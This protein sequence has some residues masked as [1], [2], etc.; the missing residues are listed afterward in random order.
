[1][2]IPRWLPLLLGVLTA[3]GPVSIDMYLPA[4]PAIEAALGGAPG[5]AQV[6]LATFFA[7][8]ALGQ[9]TQGSLSDRLGRRGPLI[10]GTTLYTLASI[11]CALAPSLFWLALFRL[12]AAFGGSASMVIPRA[13]VRDLTEGQAAARLMSRLMLVMGAA[14][15]LAPSLG[16]LVLA[17]GNWQAIFWIIALYGAISTLLVWRFLPDTLPTQY[18]V[19]LGPGAQAS[20]YLDILRERDFITHALC[21]GFCSFA[22]FAYISGSPSVF[23]DHF[24]LRP[25]LFAVVFGAC[26]GGL[27]AASQINPLLVG[28]FGPSRTLRGALRVLLA[29]TLSLAAIAWLGL[30]RPLSVA[31]PL[32]ICTA[33]FGMVMP[34][35]TIGALARHAARAASASALIGTM[36]FLLGA[37]SGL[38]VGVLSDGTARPMALLLL[39]GAVAAN[40]TDRLRPRS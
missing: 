4:F 21:A 30:D 6:T 33:S 38:L 29:A 28:R 1:M 7:G 15:I 16:G 32:F 24:G 26:A 9:L 12:V 40:L 23:I 27:I 11:G 17:W 20:R 37:V 39:I 31:L 10:A 14:P 2:R 5:T 36:Q 34:N 19:K 35:A 22:M 25:G 8:L 13:I 18:R 3:V